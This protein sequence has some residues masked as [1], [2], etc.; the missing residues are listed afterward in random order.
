MYIDIG[1]LSTYT[2]GGG[3]LRR[4]KQNERKNEIRTKK[5]KKKGD[6]PNDM[7]CNV[8]QASPIAHWE[9]PTTRGKRPGYLGEHTHMVFSDHPWVGGDETKLQ[10]C[11]FSL[12]QNRGLQH[13]L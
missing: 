5:G 1:I 7:Y 2:T 10:S 3:L 4:C 13:L 12:S 9:S 8:Q 6:L 11:S